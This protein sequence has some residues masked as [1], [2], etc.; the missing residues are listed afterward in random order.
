KPN[1]YL[2]HHRS[3][4]SETHHYIRVMK[5]ILVTGATGTLGRALIKQLL[6]QQFQVN[7]LSSQQ[8]PLLP[9]EV[10]IYRG[11]LSTSNGLEEAVSNKDA[12]IHCASDPASYREVDIM[13]TQALLDAA[14]K[15]PDIHFIYI[16][17]AG[18][19]RSDYPYY[20]A[21]KKVEDM[22][23]EYGLPWSVLRT[24]QFHSF[25]LHLIESFDNN[26]D[27][28]ITIPGG[29]KFQSVDI[30][31]VAG[32]LTE[33]VKEG[34]QGLLPAMGGPRVLGFEEMVEMYLKISGRNDMVQARPLR[35]P[36]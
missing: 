33:M 9:P 2:G 36:R 16:S 14:G 32:R 17:I 4:K 24:T 34:P 21:K 5:N 35:A 12:I 26:N 8:N 31:E 11:D 18:V 23:G 25:V 27:E 3:F 19:D 29:M 20:K 7:A 1:I 30:K 22:I 10:K 13:G 28:P 15:G 6:E